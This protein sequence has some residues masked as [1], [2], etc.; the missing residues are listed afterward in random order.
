MTGD[1][2]DGYYAR[3]NYFGYR[4]WLHRPYIAHLVKVAGLR[5][6]ASVLDV[7]CGQGFF[8]ELLR[9]RGLRVFGMD[10]NEVGVQA[11][12]TSYGRAGIHFLV[13]DALRAPFAESFDAV[14]TRSLSLYN[15]ED[16]ARDSSV[17]DRLL[18]L[19]KP[20]GVLIFL[21][22]TDLHPSRSGRAWRYH[23]IDD[24][25]R[26][27]KRYPDQKVFFSSKID[28]LLLRRYAFT[29]AASRLNSILSRNFGFGGD[30]VV[31]VTKR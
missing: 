7:G 23:T 9:N 3:P 13:A 2:Y 14:F 4:E 16:F 1:S 6:G 8:S 31:I 21:Y 15:R 11:A 27:F 17:T 19:L 26:H 10:V 30:L 12:G 5:R 22:N 18:G 25:R 20:N 29:S 28:C 24:V